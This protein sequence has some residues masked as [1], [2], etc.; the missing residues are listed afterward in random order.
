[1][2]QIM[3]QDDDMQVKVRRHD[4]NC[5]EIPFRVSSCLHLFASYA[6]SMPLFRPKKFNVILNEQHTSSNA[7]LFFKIM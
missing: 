7:C 2:S 3:R 6:F 5:N 1:M 4:T